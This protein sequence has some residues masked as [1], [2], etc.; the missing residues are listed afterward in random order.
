M[1]E[2]QTF[3]WIDEIRD[4]YKEKCGEI[5]KPFSEEKFAEFVEFCRVDVYEWLKDNWKCFNVN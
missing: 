3:I 5:E 4:F 1:E 2:A